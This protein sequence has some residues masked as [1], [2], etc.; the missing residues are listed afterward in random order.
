MSNKLSFYE[1]LVYLVY[2]YFILFGICWLLLGLYFGGSFHI[3]ASSI[4]IIIFAAQA[5][6]R[7]KLTN[8]ILGILTFGISI[9]FSLEFLYMGSKTGYNAFVGFMLSAFVISII[10]AVILIFSYTKLSFKDQ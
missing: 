4:T 1:K 7:K 8:L 5:Y 3:Q 6:F 2:G 10:M 9:Y